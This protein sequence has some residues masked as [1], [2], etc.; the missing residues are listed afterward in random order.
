MVCVV[1]AHEARTPVEILKLLHASCIFL[2][3]EL[4]ANIR[5]L[6]IRKY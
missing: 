5:T 4:T 6:K 2:R 1:P 3:N